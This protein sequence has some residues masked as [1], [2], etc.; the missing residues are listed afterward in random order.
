MTINYLT[1]KQIIHS[2]IS[3]RKKK[4]WPVFNTSQTWMVLWASS[5][6]NWTWTGPSGKKEEFPATTTFFKYPFKK[7][8]LFWLL[9]ST[10]KEK[11]KTKWGRKCLRECQFSKHKRGYTETVSWNGS[12]QLCYFLMLFY[13]IWIIQLRDKLL[14][15]VS[16]LYWGTTDIALY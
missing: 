8:K 11:K 2:R 10:R 15:P 1:M 12:F 9:R 6:H 4:A 13:L 5:L 7:Y 14:W 16:F 3:D